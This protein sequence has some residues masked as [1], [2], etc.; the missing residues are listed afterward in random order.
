MYY[1]RKGMGKPM[2]K[3][4]VEMLEDQSIVSLSLSQGDE[5]YF[6]TPD[7]L[8][9]LSSAAPRAMLRILSPFDNAV[10]QRKR[11]KSLFKYD[12][13][14]EC[15]VKKENR[16][17]G[18]FCLPI[19]LNNK[20]VARLDAKASRKDQVFELLHLHLEDGNQD[21]E[22]F[23]KTLKGELNKFAAFNGCNQLRLHKLSGTD[24]KPA[25][26]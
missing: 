12:Y 24:V 5:T 8:E 21:M 3:A 14:I 10:I 13:Q 18:Y 9:S 1:L 20:L 6:S 26:L 16:K 11:I 17:Y 25:W 2:A 23:Y 4:A 15:Y 19:L 7:A 22:S